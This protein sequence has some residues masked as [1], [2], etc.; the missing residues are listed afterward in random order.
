MLC[1]QKTSLGA[2]VYLRTVQ[3]LSPQALCQ[4]ATNLTHK[5]D[6]KHNL[7][8]RST[9]AY[10][11]GSFQCNACGVVGTGFCYR[12]Q[13]CQLDLHTVC[14]FMRSSVKGRL[15]SIH[16][17]FVLS[18]LMRKQHLFVMYVEDQG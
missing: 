4:Y 17:S 1:L 5:A 6:E 8:L 3:L 14:A 11:D 16:S 12:C 9:P 10:T 13:E 18:H 15:M 7:V 2:Y